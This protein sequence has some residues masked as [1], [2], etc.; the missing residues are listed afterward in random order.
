MASGARATVHAL[1]ARSGRTGAIELRVLASPEVLTELGRLRRQTYEARG[2]VPRD[3]ALEAQRRFGTTLGLYARGVLVGGVSAWR[4]SEA[5]CSLGYLLVEVGIERHAPERVVEVGGL[6][7]VPEFQGR[8]GAVQL[9]SAA[10]ILLAGMQPELALAFATRSAAALYE[11]RCGFR[12]VGP[13]VR[14]PLTPSVEV[15]PLI[16][17]AS[18]LARANFD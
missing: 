13:F 1:A 4:L 3:G 6:F 18:D 5:L 17:T 7:V 8:G 14:H 15:A 11:Q 9:L 12:R 2:I 10:R 16:A